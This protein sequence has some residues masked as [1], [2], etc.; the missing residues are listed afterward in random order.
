[1]AEFFGEFG[2]KTGIFIGYNL[3][4]NA[5][6]RKD[7][8]A[9][10]L[11]YSSGIYCFVTGEEDCHFGTVIIGDSK[12]SIIPSTRWQLSDEV[13]GYS[14]ERGCSRLWSDQI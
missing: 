7:I 12:D 5:V 2:N 9:V 14:F 1:V 3:F 4:G 8:L 10:Q 6:V 11:G 13:K